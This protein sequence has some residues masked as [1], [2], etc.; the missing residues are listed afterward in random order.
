M[1]VRQTE[2]KIMKHSAA[3]ATTFSEMEPAPN[4]REFK[5][6]RASW[7]KE[8]VESGKLRF[9]SYARAYCLET[10]S[11]YRVNGK[12]TSRVCADLNG[13]APKGLQVLVESYECDGLEDVAELYSRFDNAESA[14]SQG[15]INQA[16]AGTNP[17]FADI[18]SKLL[19]LC[20]TG[21]A[22]A[23]FGLSCSYGKRRAEKA[24][25]LI[26]NPAFV[27]FCSR[28]LRGVKDADSRHVRRSP[29]FAAIFDTWQKHPKLAGDFWRLVVTGEGTDV[30][31]ADRVLNRYLMS[32]GLRSAGKAAASHR[33]MLVRCIHAWNAWRSGERTNLR[34]S[35]D[36]PIPPVK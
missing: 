22:M 3:L 2:L 29:V 11:W 26:K 17:I 23:I 16:F 32:V 24:A 36:K 28:I 6:G 20:V 1:A 10:G 13:S 33:E 30:N 12:H 5:E 15:D 7:I 14:R 35:P 21:M 25:L 18:P 4:D 19:N 9:A 31:A 8:Q 27:L 34:Y